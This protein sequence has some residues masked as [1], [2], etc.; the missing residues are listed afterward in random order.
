[1]KDT[2]FALALIE[3]L[4]KATEDSPDFQADLDV[5]ERFANQEMYK[6]AKAAAYRLRHSMDTVDMPPFIFRLTETAL[7]ELSL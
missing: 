2:E 7:E 5:L 3:N 6:Q 4:K 1:M